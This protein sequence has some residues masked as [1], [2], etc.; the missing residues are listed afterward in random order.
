L[1]F[2]VQS[3]ITEFLTRPKSLIRPA[4]FVGKLSFFIDG[5]RYG[6]EVTGNKCNASVFGFIQSLLA[7][8]I[9]ER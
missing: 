2:P 7:R 3:I 9:H 8:Y 1:L 5:R 6:Q 4:V